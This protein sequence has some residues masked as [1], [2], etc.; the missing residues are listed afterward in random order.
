MSD[1]PEA[2]GQGAAAERMP[3]VAPAAVERW[4]LSSG[5]VR[6]ARVGDTAATVELLRCDGGEVVEMLALNDPR[7]VRWARARLAAEE[8]QS[9]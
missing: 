5:A 3:A 7:E 4:E 6:I 1:D 8:R 9:D 2:T